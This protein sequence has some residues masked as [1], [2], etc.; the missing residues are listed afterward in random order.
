MGSSMSYD[1][2]FNNRIKTRLKGYVTRS[3][4][5][6]LKNFAEEGVRALSDA[7]PS[8]TGATASSWYYEIVEEKDKVT[9]IWCNSHVEDGV[10]I[11]VVLDSGHV[12]QSG[13]WVKGYDYIGS[14]IGP[15]RE[16]IEEYL[17][18]R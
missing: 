12:T 1:K 3:D 5:Q 2:N 13:S 10:N 7:T 4:I 16:E 17:N 14:A 6:M 8:K 9:I 18:N 15:I 11:A